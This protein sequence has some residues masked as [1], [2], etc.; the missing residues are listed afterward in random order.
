MNR[1]ILFIAL[2]ALGTESV[3]Q[4][5]RL[6]PTPAAERLAVAEHRKA[7][8]AASWTSGLDLR[9]VG[10]TVMSG[11]VVDIAVDSPD[12]RTFYVAYASGGL[13]R[14]EN[15]GT[16]FEPLFDEALTIT[17]G[18]IA[19]HPETGRIWAGTGEV[20]S[21]RSSYAGTGMYTSD[22]GGKTWQHAGLEDAH[23]IGRIALDPDNPAIA[24]AAVLGPLYSANACGGVWKTSDSGANWQRVLHQAGD[25]GDAG[26]VDLI[27]D[28]SNP[29]RLFAALWDRTRRAWDFLGNG[30]GSG[31]WESIDAGTTW[32]ELSALEGFPASEFTGRIGLA[33]HAKSQQLFALVDNQAALPTEEDEEDEEAHTPEDFK[34]M[35]TSEFAALDTAM[36]EAYLEDNN[37]PRDATAAS[38][39]ED[40]ATG[41]L[42]PRDFYDY[43]TD[44]NRALFE[45]DIAGAEVYRLQA[46]RKQWDRTH[47]EVLED[48]CYT[49]GYYFGLI[50]VDPTN[51]DQLYIAGVPLIQSEDGGETWSSIGAPNVHVD[52]HHLWIDPSNPDHLINGN[53]GGINI[54]WDSGE[55]WVKCNSPEVGQFYAVEVDNAEPYRIYGGLQDNG[56]W[57]GPSNYRDTP[58]WQQSG[59]Y[60]WTSIGGGD[61]MQIEVDPRDPNVVFTGSQFGYYSRQDLNTD[62]YTGIH[63]QHDLG[64]TPLRWNWQ[65]P[66]WLSRHQ[67]DILYM[68]SNRVH[69]SFDQGANWETLS[70]DLT[71][72]GRPGNVPF[73]TITSLQE[74]SL[75]FGQLAVGTDDGLIQV[76]RDGGYSW[77]ELTSPLPQDPKNERT[78]WVSEVLWSTHHVNRLYIGLNA[79]RLDHFESYV[80]VTEND[81]RTWK[82]LGNRNSANGL[83]AEPVNALIESED[84]E[85]LL[86]VGTDGGCYA[87]LDRG[88]SWSTLHPDLPHVPVHDLVIQERENELVIGTHGRSIW[89]ADLNP[90]LDHA[91]EAFATSWATDSLIVLEWNEQWGKKGWAWSEPRKEEVRFNVFNPDRI[92]G[93]WEWIDSTGTAYPVDSASV[94]EKGWQLI[95]VPAQ[96]TTD[97]AAV[98]F[99]DLGTY[100]MLFR[101]KTSEGLRGPKISVE[102]AK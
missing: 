2:G 96:W 95:R 49:Y 28:P 54:S 65:T 72:G 10:P 57:R 101:A 12:G 42:V 75:R 73:G 13:W 64:E 33:W 59:H 44:G 31:I 97:E 45:A 52:H 46:D 18:A 36:L 20:N 1:I 98:A 60:A 85:D 83:P 25:H 69:R 37:F 67:N 77:I 22:D 87:S 58:G 30:S 88:A 47:A 92:E 84:W 23:H 76:S 14:T 55:N 9:C 56:T 32:S 27:Q 63:P 11:R 6:T 35:T 50:E 71:R 94:V 61:G 40:V 17:L 19:V 26:A 102:A 78:L 93:R 74:S 89:V 15:H 7:S 4:R 21:S 16:S 29:N 48:V 24:Y 66:I 79:Y 82:R 43:L 62:D 53:D 8:D 3:A 91:T 90:W 51:A 80:F 38:A 86:F 5:N 34:M 81:G 41:N 39:F 70:G 99:P 100:Q 68:A